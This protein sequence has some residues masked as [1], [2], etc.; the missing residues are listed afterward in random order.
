MNR[1]EELETEL[2]EVTYVL[3]RTRNKIGLRKEQA[4]VA[5]I[6]ESNENDLPRLTVNPLGFISRGFSYLF[7]YGGKSKSTTNEDM[8]V[9]SSTNPPESGT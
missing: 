5:L 2:R 9:N 7:G 8:A 1:V 4:D 6:T 3:Q